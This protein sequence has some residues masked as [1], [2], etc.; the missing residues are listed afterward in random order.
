M[1]TKL[2]LFGLI[3]YSS[4][5]SA[6]LQPIDVTDQ[7]IK[8]APFKTQEMLFGFAAGDQVIFNFNEV[9]NKELKQ[10]ELLEYPSTT[11][12]SEYKTTKIENKIINVQ[13]N[14]VFKFKFYNGA[15]SGRICKIKIQR[16]PASIELINYKTNV[17]FKSRTDTTW[18]S[19]TKDVIIAYDTTY[20]QKYRKVLV[21]SEVK[22][23]VLFDKEQ[24]V[25]AAAGNDK[26]YIWFTLPNNTYS[27]NKTVKIIS[28]AYWV[29]VG[30]ESN[31]AWAQTSKVISSLTKT[32]TAAYF[33]PLGAYLA[34]AVTDLIIPKN[35]EKVSYQVMDE[36]NT[37]LWL[38]SQQHLV[39]GNGNGTAA[40]QKFLDNRLSQGKFYIGLYNVNVIQPIDVN[41]KVSV[42]MQTDYY[43]NEKYTDQ[44]VTPR[45]EKKVFKDP[46]IQ[47]SSVP[48]AGL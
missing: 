33:T 44:I 31:K 47:Q 13:S 38:N 48:M 4:I 39:F 42:M 20:Q 36:N 9:D 3:G 11:K 27:D 41:V 17:V 18:N 32:A 12:Y 22:E 24:R 35:G 43:Q 46:V 40:Y 15:I 28:W 6:Q 2:L 45:Y 8:I 1:K 21:K 30:E 5:A 34:G 16:I 25:R 7:S 10:V 37:K 23:E 19:Y 26:T 14:T 29:G